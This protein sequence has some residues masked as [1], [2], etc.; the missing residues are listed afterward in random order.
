[1]R[2]SDGMEIKTDGP[3]RIIEK[4]DGL[5]VAGEG[6]LCAVDSVEEGEA[7]IAD[8]RRRKESHGVQL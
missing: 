3:L 8:I 7:L 4:S 1:M 5:Y 2:F 6:M